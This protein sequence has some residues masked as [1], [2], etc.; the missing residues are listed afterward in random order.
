[1]FTIFIYVFLFFAVYTVQQIDEDDG[2]QLVPAGFYLLL[3]PYSEDVRFNPAPTP[4]VTAEMTVREHYASGALSQSADGVSR[5]NLVSVTRD[6]V[7]ALALPEDFCYYRDIQSPALQQYYSVLQALALN[8]SAPDWQADVHDNM[9]PS[10]ELIA[11]LEDTLLADFKTLA[12]LPDAGA[13]LPTAAKV[14]QMQMIRYSSNI[15]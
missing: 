5:N 11:G 15:E 14:R 10:K 4:A 12:N 8:Q 13:E 2:C 6:L 9:R 7:K 1:M 3:L